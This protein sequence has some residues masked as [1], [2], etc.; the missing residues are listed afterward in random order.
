MVLNSD[1]QLK[2]ISTGTPVQNLANGTYYVNLDAGLVTGLGVLNEAITD[3]TTWTFTITDGY[4]RY[5]L[6]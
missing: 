4:Y 2:I 1:T 5:Y 6:I 3:S